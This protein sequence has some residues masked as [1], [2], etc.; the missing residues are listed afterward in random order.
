MLSCSLLWRAALRL[1]MTVAFCTGSALAAGPA[2]GSKNFDVPRSVP[3]YFSNES[4]PMI[5]GAA[6][7]QRGPLYSGQTAAVP[8]PAPAIAAA[9]M[10]ARQHIAMAEPRGRFIRGR[11]DVPAY[12]HRAASRGW[13]PPH[14]A[15]RGNSRVAHAAGRVATR[16]VSRTT[17]H[18]VSHT[19]A[20]TAN[21]TTR[22]VS[23]HHRGRG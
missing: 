4:G 19:A 11:H 10:R 13:A 15:A 16:T 21:R 6:E 22:V 17:V 12:V 8:A 20:H 7:T 9:P 18:T 14:L 3:N 2:N 5:G 23:A 1:G